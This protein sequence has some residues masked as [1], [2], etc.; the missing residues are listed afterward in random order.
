MLNFLARF[1]EN[2]GGTD[3]TLGRLSDIVKVRLPHIASFEAQL[4]NILSVMVCEW[5]VTLVG[6]KI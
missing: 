4:E 2:I 5:P 6:W 3:K 1:Y